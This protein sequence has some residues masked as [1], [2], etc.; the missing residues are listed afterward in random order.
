MHTAVALSDCVRAGD[1]SSWTTVKTL[2][3]SAMSFREC[4]TQLSIAEL[5]RFLQE[6]T[7]S[8]S[9]Q[10][11]RNTATAI[12][13]SQTVDACG[14]MLLV[15][16]MW[17]LYRPA[18]LVTGI[19]LQIA[20]FGFQNRYQTADTGLLD[21]ALLDSNLQWLSCRP[22]RALIVAGVQHDRMRLPSEYSIATC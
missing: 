3:T 20:E 22:E 10:V 6:N 7:N 2:S 8:R 14:V 12:S 15:Y 5:S 16:R 21:I 9:S 11:A 13:E 17:Q 18:T 4:T 19:G 1:G